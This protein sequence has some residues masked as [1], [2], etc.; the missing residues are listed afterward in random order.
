MVDADEIRRRVDQYYSG[1]S[2]F[3]IHLIVFLMINIVLWGIWA[4][5]R[6]L[7][8]S[9]SVFAFPLIV[10]LGWGAGLA[11]HGIEVRSKSPARLAAIDRTVEAQMEAVHGL[12]WR[13]VTTADDYERL[14]QEAH[15]R[16]R[17]NTEFGIHFAVY[18]LINLALWFIW[19]MVSDGTLMPFPLIIM[20]FWGAGLAAHAASIYFD[21][22]RTVTARE[23]AV[24]QA[25]AGDLETKKKKRAA[26]PQTILTDDGEQLEIIEDEWERENRLSDGKS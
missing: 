21:S 25:L 23:R 19:A 9:G 3:I 14:R 26:Q 17:Q 20:G 16:F 1:R 12:D 24:Q 7:P 13:E 22:S 18:A 10:T 8:E 11:G 15:K 4:F 6:G 2:E 5:M